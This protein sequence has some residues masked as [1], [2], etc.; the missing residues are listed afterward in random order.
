MFVL[1]GDP[2]INWNQQLIEPSQRLKQMGVNVFAVGATPI[3]GVDELKTITSTIDDQSH[4]IP[5]QGY[6]QLP[7]VVP[8]IAAK[9]CR[10]AGIVNPSSG[11]WNDLPRPL[12]TLAPLDNYLLTPPTLKNYPKTPPTLKYPSNFPTINKFTPTLKIV[13][14]L[15]YGFHVTSKPTLSTY[16]MIKKLL[17]LSPTKKVFFKRVKNNMA[18]QKTKTSKKI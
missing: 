13:D 6:W 10:L 3:A 5:L 17:S 11:E 16:D 1:G 12:P 8:Q 14:E 2:S 15:P 9:A 7:G 18:H 4:V